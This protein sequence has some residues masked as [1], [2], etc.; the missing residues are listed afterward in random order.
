MPPERFG[1][2]LEVLLVERRGRDPGEDDGVVSPDHA[3]RTQPFRKLTERLDGGRGGWRLGVDLPRISQD[4][5]LEVVAVSSGVQFVEIRHQGAGVAGP[6]DDRVHVLRLEGD[7]GHLVPI[8]RVRDRAVPF[9]EATDHPLRIESGD[10]GP[11][12]CADDHG[13]HLLGYRALSP[14]RR[15]PATTALGT[16]N[17]ATAKK[18]SP[19]P[20]KNADRDSI[21]NPR[22][23]EPIPRFL[24]RKFSVFKKGTSL[25]SC[26]IYCMQTFWQ[27]LS[28]LRLCPLNETYFTFDPKEYNELFDKELEKVIARTSDPKHRQ[29]LESMRGFDWIAYIAASVRNAG[30]P[31][32]PRRARADPR[33]RGEAAHGQLFRGFDERISG[34]MDLRFKRSRGKRHPEHGREGKNRGGTTCPPFP[35]TRSASPPA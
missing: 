11:A 35:S 24:A 15:V 13:R 16:G 21:R 34:P 4:R 12:A 5:E 19:V 26:H 23:M 3:P 7:P 33:H 8:E 28:Q 9:L 2:P 14:V 29:A 27:W 10:V 31:R 22:P 30:L 17:A 1:Q 18:R 32:L 6:E 25:P 20:Q